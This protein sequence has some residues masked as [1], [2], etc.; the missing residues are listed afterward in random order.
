MDGDNAAGPDSFT[1]K[2][3]T[4]SWDIIATDV[5]IA[6]VSFFCRAELPRFITS[7]SI[8]LVPKVPNPQDFSNFWPISLCNFINKVLSRLLSDRVAVF[9][10]KIISPQQSGFVRGRNITENYLLAQEVLAGIGKKSREGNVALKLDMAKAYDRVSWLHLTRVLRKFGFGERFIDM[11]WRLVSNVWFSVMVNE[12]AYGFFKSSRDDVLI[13]ANGPSTSLR[14]V[15]RV[16]DMYQRSSG[17]LLNAQKSGYLVHPSLPS[18][19]HR[20]IER[21]TG[22]SCQVFPT[23]D[24]QSCVP[25]Y[26]ESLCQLSVGFLRAGVEFRT[27]SSLWAAFMREKYCQGVHPCQVEFK[28]FASATWRRMLDVSRQVEL[29]MLWLIQD[30]SWSLERVGIGSSASTRGYPNYS[31][32][33]GSDRAP[34]QVATEVW[35]YFGGLCGISLGPS[36]RGRLA[37]WRLAFPVSERQRTKLLLEGQLKEHIGAQSFMQLYDWSLQTGRRFGFKLICWKSVEGREFTLNTDSC[38]KGNPG[39]CGGGGVVRDAAGQLLVSFSAFLEE[40]TSLQ[41]EVLALL[42][43]LRICARRGITNISAELDSLLLVG[44]LQC[45]FHCPWQI[46]WEVQQIWKLIETPSRFSHCFRKANQVADILANVG[47]AHPHQ[48]IKLYEHWSD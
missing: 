5:Y 26:R 12:A 1:S 23:R 38:S 11:T 34:T 47:V 45:R 10:P 18:A 20:V 28:P 9:L 40:A 3:F 15:M 44:I 42:M 22:F 39:K 16:L 36:V 6:V 35:A 43:G 8:V 41:A 29:S 46:Q 13:L 48:A 2:F 27:S 37:A 7:T 17:Q 31:G 25:L 4:F 32:Y 33:A 19:R 30:G 14:R 24:A 21:I